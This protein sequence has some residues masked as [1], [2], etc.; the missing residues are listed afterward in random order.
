MVFGTGAEV[1][2]GDSG[3]G[4]NEGV[5][6][7]WRGG[8]AVGNSIAGSVA[9]PMEGNSCRRRESTGGNFCRR[10]TRGL[11]NM[12]IVDSRGRI[13]ANGT[14][15][16]PVAVVLPMEHHVVDAGIGNINGGSIC[17]PCEG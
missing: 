14:G 9:V 7:N 3:I 12:D 16:L 6:V 4:D 5:H 13:L 15:V 8:R 10:Q 11:D 1:G 17:S 2:E